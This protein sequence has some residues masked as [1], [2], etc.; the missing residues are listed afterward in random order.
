MGWHVPTYSD[1]KILAEFLGGFDIAGGQLKETGNSHWY[2]PNSGA[3]NNSGF[4]ALQG[5]ARNALGEFGF[6]GKYS[7]FWSSSEYNTTNA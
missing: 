3:N 6:I 2:I 1:W 5:G 4:T 7:C